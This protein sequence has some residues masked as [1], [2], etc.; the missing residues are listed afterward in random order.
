MLFFFS[1]GL[2]YNCRHIAIDGE[3]SSRPCS[4]QFSCHRYRWRHERYMHGE[5]FAR[6]TPEHET[7]EVRMMKMWILVPLPDSDTRP[8]ENESKSPL[9]VAQKMYRKPEVLPRSVRAEHTIRDTALPHLDP[10]RTILAWETPTRLD[11]VT[12]PEKSLDHTTS[13]GHSE[14]SAMSASRYKLT[15]DA[16]LNPL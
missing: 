13:P 10:G 4:K 3:G 11:A 16:L 2:K 12:S 6:G 14:P 8:E 1:F 7:K 15:L 9:S 5:R